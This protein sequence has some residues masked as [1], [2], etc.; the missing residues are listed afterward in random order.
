MKKI[1]V[2]RKYKKLNTLGLVAFAKG[3]K[4][5]GDT[6][7]NTPPHADTAVYG[8]AD[9]LHEANTKRQINPSKQN[10]EAE[11]VCRNILID[12]LDANANY[13][14]TISNSVARAAGDY[15]AGKAVVNRIGFLVAGKGSGKRNIGFIDSG[16]GWAHAHE[17]KS[18][19][20]N[21]GHIWKAGV[22]EAKGTPPTETSYMF[23]LESDF[24]FTGLASGTVLAYCHGCVIPVNPKVQPSG[25]APSGSILA[26]SATNLPMNKSKHPMG[27]INDSTN[28]VFGEWR[29]IVIP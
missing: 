26:K 22:P 14:E 10:T 27:N 29:Y 11:Q 6:A 17:A 25:S 1:K 3:T 15:E 21:E 12:M 7:A 18:R 2:S 9:D 19:K 5:Q 28:V 23:S 13:L 16:V 4:F 8:A 24:I 20:G